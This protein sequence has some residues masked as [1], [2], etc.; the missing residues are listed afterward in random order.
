MAITFGKYTNAVGDM[1][2]VDNLTTANWYLALA[3]IVNVSDT[4]FIDGTTDLPTLNGYISGG[5]SISVLFSGMEND[6][7]K[8]KLTDPSMWIAAEDGYSFRCVILYNRNSMVPYCYWDY[9]SDINVP[10][11]NHVII[12]LDAINGILQVN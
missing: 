2:T 3:D 9:G 11:N 7:Y 12:T 10:E 4:L 6:I 8:L 1:V 5:N